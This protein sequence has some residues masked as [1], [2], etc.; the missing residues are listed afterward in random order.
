MVNRSQMRAADGD[1]ERVAELLRT[2]H[3]EGRLSQDELLERIESTFEAKTFRDLD[4]VIE[5][6]PIPRGTHHALVGK[7]RSAQPVAR[8]QLGRRVA[9]GVLNVNWWIY[10]GVNVLCLVIWA[11]IFLSGNAGDSSFWPIWIAGPWGVFLGF[12]E[13]LY[14]ST[15]ND[16]SGVG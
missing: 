7:P 12:W 16:A 5:D 8:K 4:Q 3:E 11:A 9:R 14:R 2:A 10:G 1:R 13:M 6:L 15:D